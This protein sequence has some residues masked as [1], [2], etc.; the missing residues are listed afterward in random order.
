MIFIS[1]NSFNKAYYSLL[2]IAYY[3]SLKFDNSRIGRVKDLGK[4]VYQI[5]DDPFRLCFLKG[6]NINP[7]FAYSEFSWIIEGSNKLKPLKHFISDYQKFSDDGNTLNGA[8]GYRLKKYFCM[9]Q[10]KKA[11]NELKDNNNSRRVVLTMYSPHDL[12]IESN[13]IP[14]NTTIYLKIKNKKLDITILNRSN[15]LFLGV[16]YNVFVFYLLQAYLS[17]EI[18]CDIGIQTHFSDSLH[19][20]EHDVK[21]VKEILEKNSLEEIDYIEKELGLF[22]N[23]CYINEP[24]NLIIDGNF[25]SFNNDVF[26]NIFQVIKD[27]KN[28]NNINYAIIPR[29]LVGYCVYN[30]LKRKKN[31]NFDCID[32]FENIGEGKKL[33]Y[34]KIL[35]SLKHENKNKIVNDLNDISVNCISKV[36]QFKNII[37]NSNSI[38]SIN[39][40]DDNKLVNIM[41]LVIVVES[42]SSNMYDREIRNNLFEKIKDVVNDLDINIDDVFFFS[43]YETDIKKILETI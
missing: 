24:H 21:K 12:N 15:D 3:K 37:S 1:E 34:L 8:Y 7:F 17:K 33:S 18:G 28:T 27:V 22:D 6:R 38:I 39:V 10:L 16:P 9:D 23:R 19:L 42:L 40:D 31:I 26:R 2:E 43:K 11:V 41:L 30:W 5:K 35:E 29:N 4:V 20:Y 25:E 36:D 13:D 32:Y 14:C